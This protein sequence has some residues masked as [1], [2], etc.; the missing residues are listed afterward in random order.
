MSATI[1]DIARHLKISTS[2][3]SYA[4]NG[5]PRTVPDEVRSRVLETARELDYR[6]NRIARSLVT[7]R[8]NTIG[9]VPPATHRDIFRSPFIQ[10]AF[11]ALVN[12][13]EELGQDLL[14]FTGRDRTSLDNVN[15]DLMDARIDGV[16][17]IA[18]SVQSK[19]IAELRKR[20]FPYCVI[21]GWDPANQTTFA[22][23]NALG[24]RQV[25][26]HLVDL[27]HRHIVHIAG[28]LTHGD[29]IQRL[30]EF[31]R[32]T[33]AND[34][35]GGESA[36]IRSTFTQQGG[37]RSAIEI[38]SMNPRPTAI[39]AANDEIAMGVFQAARDHGVSI[40]DEFSVVAFDDSAVCE[41]LT[42]RLTSVRQPLDEIAGAGL[43]A[44]VESI[45]SKTT[46]HGSAFPTELIVREST[47][48]L[49]SSVI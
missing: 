38:F 43:R 6:P 23:D 21:A 1:K 4:L 12:E 34:L 32:Q 31:L 17:F 47:K 20:G 24:V 8:S 40:P 2:T 3:V 27:G 10:S 19:A 42:P 5:G 11:N 26:N 45:K 14:L 37:Y 30:A 36:V 39:F 33:E 29:A 25:V 49:K 22:A 48:S 15:M 16:V 28:D 44:V 46:F 13:A 35:V 7:G 18:P 41:A 9:V